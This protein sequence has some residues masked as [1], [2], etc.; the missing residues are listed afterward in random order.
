MQQKAQL[1]EMFLNANTDAAMLTVAREIGVQPC[2][3]LYAEGQYIIR[4]EDMP[5]VVDAIQIDCYSLNGAY[6]ALGTRNGKFVAGFGLKP[7]G[8]AIDFTEAQY[9]A[10]AAVIQQS[11]TKI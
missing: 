11:A 9:N 5:K 2:E 8:S 7:N 10:S 3:N 1:R 4:K 6:F